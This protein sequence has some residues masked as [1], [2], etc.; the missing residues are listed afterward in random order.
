MRVALRLMVFVVLLVSGVPG[1]QTGFGAGPIP[2][3]CQGSNPCP[4][5][6]SLENL[7]GFATGPGPVPTPLPPGGAQASA[8]IG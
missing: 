6:S 7:A 2:W 1:V 5:L 8:L 3:P 4:N